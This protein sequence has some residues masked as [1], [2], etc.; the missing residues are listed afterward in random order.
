M[1][2]F[3]AG[4]AK[5]LLYGICI[6]VFLLLSLL[7]IIDKVDPT[8]DTQSSDDEKFLTV[9]RTEFPPF[10]NTSDKE[11]QEAGHEVC[12]ALQTKSVDS[13]YSLAG[14]AGM[15]TN[16]LNALVKASVK[17]YCPTPMTE[18]LQKDYP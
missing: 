14:V 18:L 16:G 9:A 8:F 12:T 1:S 3:R 7:Y 17:V 11:L 13:L 10:K 15:D 5:A 2:K 6:P 4:I